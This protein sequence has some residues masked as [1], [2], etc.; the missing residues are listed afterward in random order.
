V[1]D[2]LHGYLRLAAALLNAPKRFSGPWNFGPE[3]AQGLTVAEVAERAVAAWG[4]GEV[5]HEAEANAPFEHRLLQ[6]NIDKAKLDLG[7]HPKW[8][9]EH[10]IAETVDWYKRVEAGA[11]ARAVSSQQI[12]RFM[13]G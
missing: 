5:V 12:A 4:K 10:A 6:L 1:L 13:E 8:S 7:W 11:A 2:P 3:L 9:S